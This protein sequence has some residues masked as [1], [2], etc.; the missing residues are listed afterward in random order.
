M[1][2]NPLGAS[3]GSQAVF[4]VSGFRP[5]ATCTATEAAVPVYD[6]EISAWQAAGLLVDGVS[7]V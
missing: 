4:A 2:T 1:T 7:C 5:G 3:E 6:Q